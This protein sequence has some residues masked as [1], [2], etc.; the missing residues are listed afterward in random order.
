MFLEYYTFI[1]TNGNYQIEKITNNKYRIYFYYILYQ[2][3]KII[4]KLIL[5]II[6]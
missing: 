3:P 5:L 2:I 1:I 6:F 4:T